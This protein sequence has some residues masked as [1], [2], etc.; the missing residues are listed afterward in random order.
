[1]A[2][3]SRDHLINHG[4]RGDAYDKLV[5]CPNIFQGVSFVPKC[6]A[7]QVSG[8]KHCHEVGIR[9]NIQHPILI[10][11][12]DKGHQSGESELSLKWFCLHDIFLKK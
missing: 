1:V 9:G 8:A 10:A 2:L 11:S 7:N 12:G 5:V 3:G 4:G 6:D